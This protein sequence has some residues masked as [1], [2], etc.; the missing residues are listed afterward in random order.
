MHATKYRDLVVLLFVLDEAES[1]AGSLARQSPELQAM[2]EAVSHGA[3]LCGLAITAEGI[4][5][6]G[7]PPK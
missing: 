3:D 2:A 4:E 5:G 7:S 1:L 6:V